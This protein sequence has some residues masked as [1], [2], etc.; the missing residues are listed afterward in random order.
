MLGVAAVP[1]FSPGGETNN[2]FNRLYTAPAL[3]DTFR[4]LIHSCTLGARSFRVSFYPM[5]ALE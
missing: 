4:D 5:L 1:A 2:P 3:W